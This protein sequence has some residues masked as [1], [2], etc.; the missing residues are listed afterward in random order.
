[1][2]GMKSLGLFSNDKITP[3]ETPLDTLCA[4]LEQKMQYE[5]GERDMVLLQHKFQIENK[6]GSKETRTS[7]LVEYGDPEGYSAMAKLVG[8]P[9]AVACLMVLDG[10]ISQK[11]ILAPVTWN[12]AEPL[13]LELKSKYGIEL[14]EVTLP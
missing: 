3:R 13:L 10:R 12:I 5:K 14:K 11:G 8:V 2:D 1:M 6:D 7:T 4:T 9:C